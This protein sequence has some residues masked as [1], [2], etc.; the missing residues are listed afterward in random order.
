MMVERQHVVDILGDSLYHCVNSIRA[1]HGREPLYQKKSTNQI[2]L[3][4]AKSRTALKFFSMHESKHYRDIKLEDLKAKVVL[5]MG[6][7][8][9]VKL[10]V[11]EPTGTSIAS[12]T[13][14]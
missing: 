5:G 10:V 8:G 6:A 13:I 12:S 11:H 2:M 4:E 3:N 14:F 7:Y 9:N 1:S